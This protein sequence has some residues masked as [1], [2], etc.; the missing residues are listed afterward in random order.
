MKRLTI[1]S[2]SV[3]LVLFG[4]ACPLASG[5]DNPIGGEEWKLSVMP[6][7]WMAGIEGDVT[8]KSFKADI[9]IG[10]DEIWDALDFGGQVHIEAQKGRWGLLFDP[11]FLALSSDDIS[12][13]NAEVEF[14]MWIV[15]LGGFYRLGD[16]P[17]G[18]V[19]G[20]AMTLD[21]L[22]GGRYW[23]LKQKVE[24]GPLSRETSQDWIDPFIG[25]R[26]IMEMNDWMVFH[27]RGDIGGFAISNDAS[28]FT[29]NVYAGPAFKV[30]D[31]VTIVAGYRALGL[32]KERGSNLDADLTMH[33][34]QIGV[35]IRF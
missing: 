2:I 34:P 22:A 13:P 12:P 21:V 24:L 15:E 25:A 31:K 9:D 1:T 32:N 14:D 6:Y 33:G 18:G 5:Q 19:N 35:H 16:W 3:V 28:E 4:L 30:S 23:N 10:F 7:F 27:L 8:V 29:W 11:A 20:R 26:L 17:T